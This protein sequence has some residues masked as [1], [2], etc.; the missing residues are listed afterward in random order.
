[1]VRDILDFSRYE[2]QNL[3][4]EKT[5]HM[6]DIM[7]MDIRQTEGNAGFKLDYCV[8]IFRARLEVGTKYGYEVGIER[9]YGYER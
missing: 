6:M 4:L 9:I 2:A 8:D 5:K 1:M 3:H 7:E